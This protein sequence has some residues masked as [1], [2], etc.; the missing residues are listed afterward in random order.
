MFVYLNPS[1]CVGRGLED[2]KQR[3]TP[4]HS[5]WRKSSENFER[6]SQIYIIGTNA[7]PQ[8]HVVIHV[9]DVVEGP[10]LG[11]MYNKLYQLDGPIQSPTAEL[12]H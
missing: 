10:K 2:A 5:P 3:E 12:A 8:L 7:S 1:S 4:Q 6:F 11:P 9:T